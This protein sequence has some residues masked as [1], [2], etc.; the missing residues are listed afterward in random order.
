[1][2]AVLLEFKQKT[3]MPNFVKSFGH[4]QK[5]WSNFKAAFV[6]EGFM[7]FICQRGK[8]IATGVAWSES[9][10]VFSDEVIFSQTSIM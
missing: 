9:W 5:Y 8:L 10:L 3:F 4:I 1:M 2:D 6:M 7:D